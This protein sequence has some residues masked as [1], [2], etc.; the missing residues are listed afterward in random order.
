MS[1]SYHLRELHGVAW[2]PFL[3]WLRV[4]ARLLALSEGVSTLPACPLADRGD[5]NGR[6]GQAL[7]PAAA[8]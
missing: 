1:M 2:A 7:L 6:G 4:T 3:P 5:R 8:F